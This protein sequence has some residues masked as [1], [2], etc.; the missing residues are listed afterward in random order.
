MKKIFDGIRFLI[1][2]PF[3]FIWVICTFF[4]LIVYPTFSRELWRS[5][6]EAITGEAYQ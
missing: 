1:I 6:I 5:L 2:F 3:F 4:M